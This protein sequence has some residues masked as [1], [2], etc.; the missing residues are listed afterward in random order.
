MLF[1]ERRLSG[2]HH[3]CE[4]TLLV[5]T[6]FKTPKVAASCTRTVSFAPESELCTYHEASEVPST[7]D[8]ASLLW[9]SN[10][11]FEQFRRSRR[12]AVYH[13]QRR[14]EEEEDHS[15]SPDNDHTEHASSLTT[16]LCQLFL[17]TVQNQPH[18]LALSDDDS[19]WPEDYQNK[20]RDICFQ[21]INDQ[22]DNNLVDSPPELLWG[23]EK[24]AFPLSHRRAT[25]RA[26]RSILR[27]VRGIQWERN[28]GI[29]TPEDAGD[30]MRDSSARWS[31]DAVVW[32]QWIARVHHAIMVVTE[33]EA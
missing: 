2:S 29:W 17:D 31:N 26:S 10:E 27:E 11:D 18:L 16:Q 3:S 7:S 22:N 19:L 15:G 20:I 9:Y 4:S 25:G 23:L 28:R 1:L 6:S 12:A 13:E 32:A 33:Q 21:T 30:L 5:E 8:D 24:H 14:A